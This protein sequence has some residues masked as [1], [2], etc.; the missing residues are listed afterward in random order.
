MK[1]WFYALL[2][3]VMH[4]YF[5]RVAAGVAVLALVASGGYFLYTQYRDLGRA[6]R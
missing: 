4:S 2:G 6:P 3:M 5:G 1:F